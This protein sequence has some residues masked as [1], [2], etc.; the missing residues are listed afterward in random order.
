MSN[1]TQE[2][3]ELV[4]REAP[5]IISVSQA[6][7]KKLRPELKK[8]MSGATPSSDGKMI[9]RLE[10]E[11]QADSLQKMLE[12]PAIDADWKP[13]GVTPPP[14]AAP[15]SGAA[16][17]APTPPPGSDPAK[18]DVPW[19]KPAQPLATVL[20]AGAGAALVGGGAYA[21]MGGGPS[22]QPAKTPPEGAG[23][24]PPGTNL[25]GA[26]AGT[27]A[28]STEKKPREIGKVAPITVV[29]NTGELEARL[30][31]LNTEIASIKN[32]EWTQ[33]DEDLWNK[34]QADLQAI[35]DKAQQRNMWG[36][37]AERIGQALTQFF[38]AKKGLE[39]G[40]DMS[41]L[42]F[43]KTD[44]GKKTDSILDRLK[45]DLGISQDQK[46]GARETVKTARD[47]LD[48]LK[49]QSGR[50]TGDIAK[51]KQDATTATA[52][53]KMT[54][55]TQNQ[56]ADISGAQMDSNEGMN[57]GRIDASTRNALLKSLGSRI[58]DDTKKADALKKVIAQIQT[59]KNPDDVNDKNI[60][61]AL[62]LYITG[63][64]GDESD[65]DAMLPKVDTGS[66]ESDAEQKANWVREIETQ[67]GMSIGGGAAPTES[68]RQINPGTGQ[69]KIFYSDG[70]FK[71]FEKGQAPA[72]PGSN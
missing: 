46:R 49:D 59:S 58:K 30:T 16:A 45:A 15:A 18:A 24:P 2:A 38:A 27:P 62:R 21:A 23:G 14:A 33:Q 60:A 54:A 42:K 25:G 66:W 32:T 40:V 26:S 67:T 36:E 20:K 44:W 41:G 51:M 48:R 3:T 11:A 52:Q 50:L 34:K 12:G 55:Q 39:T 72:Q 53:N 47:A 22:T 4:I 1:L 71:I 6:T 7:W 19:N 28:G 68:R 43:D 9:I 13:G 63:G 69:T 35:A 61:T 57:Q 65:F 64:L 56:D 10:G 8:L 31:Q 5:E 29:A 17:A 37:V 70:S